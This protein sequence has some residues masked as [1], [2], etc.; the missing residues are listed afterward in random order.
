MCTEYKA[1]Y[2]L[3]SACWL[4]CQKC[5][6]SLTAA[7]SDGWAVDGQMAGAVDGLT[8]QLVSDG[9][10][11][12]RLIRDHDQHSDGKANTSRWPSA[13]LMVSHRLRRW[14]NISSTF[15]QRLVFSDGLATHLNLCVVFFTVERV[16]GDVVML[17]SAKAG[18]EH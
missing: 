15:G 14:A 6:F 7:W 4:C 2:Q 8:A 5:R 10:A 17:P 3:K 11:V 9:A 16:S 18:N 1:Y 12:T 13:G